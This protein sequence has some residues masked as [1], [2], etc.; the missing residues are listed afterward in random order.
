MPN[1]SGGRTMNI[2]SVLGNWAC[3]DTQPTAL[4]IMA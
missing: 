3:P 4:P 2:S 1:Q